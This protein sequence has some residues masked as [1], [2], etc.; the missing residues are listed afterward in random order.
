M[1]QRTVYDCDRCNKQNVVT[2]QI[3]VAVK[4]YCD[5]A[6]SMDTEVEQ[7]DLC[8][9]CLRDKLRAETEKMSYDDGREWVSKVK[10]LRRA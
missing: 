6:G 3:Q 1:A 5:A 2:R 8:I 10:D 9:D 7:V 4:R